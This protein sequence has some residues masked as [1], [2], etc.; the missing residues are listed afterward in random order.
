MS[1]RSSMWFVGLVALALGVGIGSQ[2]NGLFDSGSD[3]SGMRSGSGMTSQAMDDAPVYQSGPYK[4]SVAVNPEAPQVGDNKLMIKVMDA[5]GNPV[6]DA[7][8]QA[9][10]EMSAMG[11]M[12]AMRAPA[13]VEQVAPGEYAGPMN[14]E[15]SGE[16]P[17]SISIEK[18][19]KG[20][21]ALSF[22]MA[23]GRPGLQLASGGVKVMSAGEMSQDAAGASGA[24]PTY[25][26]GPFKFDVTIAPETPRVGENRLIIDLRDSQGKPVSG[27]QIKAVA[28]M[29]AMGAMPPMQAPADF[30]ET[31]PG[32]Y[33]GA[34]ALSMSGEWPLSVQIRKGGMGSQR[35]SFD[36]ATGRQGLQVVAGAGAAGQGGM[37]SMQE[38]PANAIRVD[39]RRRQLIGVETSKVAYR[40][41]TRTIRAVGQVVYDETKLSEVTLRFNGWIGELKADYVG[42]D[43]RKGDVLFTVYG[44][45]LLAAQQQYLEVLRGRF[46][47][48][49]RLVEAA[50]KRLLL[51]DMAPSQIEE[52]EQRGEPLDYVPITAPRGG[53][54][55]EKHVVI[56]SA[57][58]AGTTL[59]RIADLSQVWVEAEVYEAE[60]PLV[61][62]G[63]P[64]VVTL[65]YAP[66][67]TYEAKVDYVY[68]YLQ[69]MTRTGRVR[70]TLNNPDGVLKPDMYAEVKLKADLGRSLVVPEE[71]VLFAGDSRVVFV[72]IGGGN[73]KPQKIKA[74]QQAG[75]YIE[76]LEGLRAG[77][78]V[79]TSGNFLIASE[80][81]L[82][83]G[84]AQW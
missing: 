5:Q 79:V 4:V 73:L 10:G 35:I 31:E 64:A 43:V 23:T 61:K 80:A 82:K 38:V 41:L 25:R 28:E 8:I 22:E 2:L 57:M 46:G 74:G 51:W 14:I 52:L 60:L 34:F 81:R 70:L 1:K 40:D 77:D 11:A 9:F 55:V 15:M 6:E 44:P 3:D 49:S 67:K 16:W 13:S 27:A 37:Q 32:R 21:T 78:E 59:M 29:P 20:A 69:G 66:G 56:G 24:K 65:P 71:A 50:R 12:P 72:D 58:M 68:P 84:I 33:L 48:G 17:L 26:A 62:V 63:M 36:M 45:E 18:P 75:D 54:V 76:V 39:S 7:N 47:Q 53:T 42:K 83:T 19:G 30:N